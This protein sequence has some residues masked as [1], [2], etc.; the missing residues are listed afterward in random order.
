MRAFTCLALILSG[1]LLLACGGGGGESPTPTP[2]RLPT[3]EPTA[4]PFAAARAAEADDDPSLPGQFVDVAGIYGGP[5]GT[6]DTLV[7]RHI[8]I[9]AQYIEDGN[10]SPP[11]GGPHWGSGACGTD[12]PTAPPFCG[13]APWGVFTDP[14]AAESLV[15]SMEHGGLVIWYNTADE[16]VIDDLKDVVIE[17][18]TRDLIVMTPYSGMEAEHIAITGWSRLDK[19]PV[20]EYTRERI[21]EFIEAHARRFNPEGF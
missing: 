5:Y 11:A 3:P 21:E 10:S 8:Q 17:R 14:W 7:N 20:E 15:H 4:E 6:P 13:P 9:D 19:F 2:T 1:A 12:P 18:I 16:D